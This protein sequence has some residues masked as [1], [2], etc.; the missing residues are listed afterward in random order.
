MQLSGAEVQRPLA[1]VVI[2]G[3]ISAT[4][5]TLFVLPILYVWSQRKNRK[6]PNILPVIL[7][8]FLL[9]IGNTVNAQR[10]ISLAAALDSV[11]S[12]NPAIQSSKLNVQRSRQLIG[13]SADIPKMSILGDY[14]QINS[15][16]NDTRFGI[17]QSISFPTVYSRQ[18]SLMEAEAGRSELESGLT[19]VRV[20]QQ[21][22]RLFYTVLVMQTKQKLL[23]YAD[24]IY[25]QF[26]QKAALRFEKGE[27]N[28][29]EKTAAE[30]QRKQI[31]IQL[32]QLSSD[33]KIA[34]RNFNILLNVQDAVIPEAPDIKMPPIL[35][36]NNDNPDQSLAYKAYEQ[37][38]VIA[39]RNSEFQKSRLL[40][41]LT[42]GYNNQSIIG[43]QNVNGADKYY[44]GGRR[45]SSV[46]A[47]IGIPL[48]AAAQNSRMKAARTQVLQTQMDAYLGKQQLTAAYQNA[49]EQYNNQLQNVN[50]YEAGLLNNTETIFKIANQQY[51]NGE[52]NY[53]EWVMVINQAVSVRSDYADAVQ[54]LN[55][56]SVHL[57]TLTANQ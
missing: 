53:L 21:V 3:L 15:V 39:R 18:R 40:P 9:L 41:D 38:I 7:P 29:L 19:Q 1:T 55:E 13:T 17:S 44:G 32:Q 20:R 35:S 46:Q 54:Q 31:G 34:I 52:I 28:L 42:V 45:F 49:V 47:S 56:L 30:I 27:T 33:L 50:T 43:I 48:F 51:V 16:S 22:K 26:L 57:E 5:L 11:S 12:N 37:D 10:P 14:G 24:S 4:F 2:G 36:A 6:R 8:V 23:A 25:D